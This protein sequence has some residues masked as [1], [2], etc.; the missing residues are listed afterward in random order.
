VE[1]VGDPVGLE[2]GQSQQFLGGGGG[3]RGVLFGGEGAEAVPGLRG[4]D[5]AG[6]ALGD[7][8]AELFEHNGGSV[9]I[10]GEDGFGRR[11]AG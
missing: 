2:H 4:D 7:D 5:D 11:L 3:Q 10:D 9:E 1:R 8:V 6:A